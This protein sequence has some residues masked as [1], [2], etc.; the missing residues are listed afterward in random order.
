MT[1]W[2][3]YP[4]MPTY[5]VS[6]EGQLRNKKTKRVLSL[7]RMKNGYLQ[8]SMESKGK[9][10]KPTMNRAVALTFLGEPEDPKMVARMKNGDRADN[11]LSNIEW[12]TWSTVNTEM[13][14]SNRPGL[15]HAYMA[16]SEDDSEQVVYD[17]KSE[18]IAASGVGRVAFETAVRDVEPINGRIWERTEKVEPEEDADV[19][20]IPGYTDCKASSDGLIWKHRTGWTKGSLKATDYYSIVFYDV[21][22]RVSRVIALTFIGLP[23]TLTS[24]VNHM[25]GDTKNNALSNLEWTTPG[26]N[27][28]HA[29]DTGLNDNRVSV[30]QLKD[31]I[32]VAEYTSIKVAGQAMVTQ[33]LSTSLN[34]AKVCITNSSRN[35]SKAYGFTWSR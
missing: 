31:G 4:V 30:V 10:H 17:S 35:G 25:D 22:E 16:T 23:P 18:A 2:K 33:E 20:I 28:Q 27:T 15:M 3:V 8:A 1:K 19:R 14:N 7:R 9:K 12:A 13:D 5:E 11:R 34:A 26:E 24:Q 32:K 6:D 21:E 29:V